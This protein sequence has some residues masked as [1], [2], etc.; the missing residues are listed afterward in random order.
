MAKET[1]RRVA[2][3]APA[4]SGQAPRSA[5]R[6][7]AIAYGASAGAAIPIAPAEDARGVS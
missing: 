6:G 5:A 7:S 4:T 1:P 3:S 2:G